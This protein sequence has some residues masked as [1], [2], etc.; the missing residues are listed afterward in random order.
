[1]FGLQRIGKTNVGKPLN[2]KELSLEQRRV[3][4]AVKKWFAFGLLAAF[5]LSVTSTLTVVILKG[6]KILDV[7][8]T[9]VISLLGYTVAQIP[10][11][12]YAIIK[13]IFAKP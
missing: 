9:V 11:M 2:D 4:I 10:P 3:D 12:L 1:M 7:S 8:D 13:L 5:L 6:A